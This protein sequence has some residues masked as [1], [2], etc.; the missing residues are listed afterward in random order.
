MKKKLPGTFFLVL[1]LTMQF[2][3]SPAETPIPAPPACTL[4]YSVTVAEFDN[5]ADRHGQQNPAAGFAAAMTDILHESGWFN[6][7]GDTEMRQ[8]ALIEQYPAASGG[9]DQAREDPATGRISPAQFL[10]RGSVTRVGDNNGGGGEAEMNVTVHLLD[11]N[12]GRTR[13]SADFIGKSASKGFRLGDNGS[14]L[15]GVTGDVGPGKDNLA[16]AVDDAAGQAVV[17][18]IGQLDG[19]PWEGTVIMVKEGRIIINRG[20]REGVRVGSRFK[21]G[22]VEELVDP[23]TG[24]ILDSRMIQ[25]GTI[26]I[27]EA[28]EQIAYC[29][30]ESG[31]QPITRGMTVFAEI[32]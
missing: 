5:E 25:V 21:V 8:A 1:I 30:A 10:I 20:S 9:T 6:V 26:V 27:T 14:R 19:I 4:R 3:P 13:A 16:R 31:S 23:D 15:N 7:L 12:T 24:E 2:A 22:S 29:A 28:R 17:F 32:R 18:L 11:S